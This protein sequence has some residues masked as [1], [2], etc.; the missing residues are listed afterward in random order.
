VKSR[1]I[2]DRIQ[3]SNRAIRLTN[4]TAID[5]N[6][7]PQ[8]TEEKLADSSAA[9]AALSAQLENIA[10]QLSALEKALSDS[11]SKL[12]VEQ[13]LRR[14]AEQDQ[15][16]Y[17]AKH[18]EVEG[19]LAALRDEC[20]A[21][22]EELAFKESELEE[23]RL[24]LEIERE[25]HSVELEDARAEAAIDNTFDITTPG[26]NKDNKLVPAS[27]ADEAYVKKLEDELR[28]ITRHSAH[29]EIGKKPEVTV[30]ISRLS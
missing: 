28:R 2:E 11:R 13:K 21:V 14:Q 19:N 4:I 24:E 20:D 26:K 7:Q 10:P 18:R 30:V 22:H 29:S 12:K 17:E 23:T 3:H 16:D 5:W 15:D 6:L 27:D 8:N 1:W 25:R 9:N